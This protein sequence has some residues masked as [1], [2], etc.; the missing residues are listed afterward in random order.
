VPLAPRPVA[1]RATP[2]VVGSA[3]RIRARG[4]RLAGAARTR[5]FPALDQC[6]AREADL[7]GRID[8]DD[9]HEDLVAFL[10]LAADI[11]H[12]LVRHLA[13]VEQAV[14]ARDDLDEGAE[15]HYAHDL[16][17]VGLVELGGR[18]ELLDYGDG[19]A[20]GRLLP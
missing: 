11:L 13:D 6:L 8:V 5:A 2:A 1:V 14:R 18:G 20:R 15:V 19:L 7:A 9:L 17:Q 16:A 12:A 4:L 3:I 10:H